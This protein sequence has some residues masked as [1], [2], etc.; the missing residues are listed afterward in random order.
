MAFPAG[1]LD[2]PARARRERPGSPPLTSVVGV[3]SRPGPPL[4]D[5]QPDGAGELDHRHPLRLRGRCRETPPQ[6]GHP[7][8]AEV[9]DQKAGAEDRHGREDEEDGRDAAVFRHRLKEKEDHPGSGNC[10]PMCRRGRSLALERGVS[11][12][13]ESRNIL[14]YLL[15]VG[16]SPR[17]PDSVFRLSVLLTRCAQ[18]IVTN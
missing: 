5:H 7:A 13:L 17:L 1:C 3:S 2:P 10:P 18:L 16:L 15:L 6:G 9:G 8:A 14:A 4:A 12:A 11:A